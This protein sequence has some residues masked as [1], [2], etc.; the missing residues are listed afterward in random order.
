MNKKFNKEYFKEHFKINDN[1]IE[2]E[3]ET[4]DNNNINIK[5]IDNLIDNL[6]KTKNYNNNYNIYN[7]EVINYK[8]NNNYIEII[9]KIQDKIKRAFIIDSDIY[10]LEDN[11]VESTII[12]LSNTKTK[13]KNFTLEESINQLSTESNN[14]NIKNNIKRENNKYYLV[15]PLS[16]KIEK[17]NTKEG[18]IIN[19]NTNVI[20]I[21]AMKMENNIEVFERYKVIKILVK[22]GDFVQINQNLIELEL[23]E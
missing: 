21:S 3:F 5:K 1:I 14:I 2:V 7:L 23:I 19:P 16:G 15:P 13:F 6:I 11:L 12:D 4:D 8:N 18:D 9:F 17:I 22:E 20:I 10:I